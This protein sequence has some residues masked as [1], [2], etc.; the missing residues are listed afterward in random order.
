MR[1][2]MSAP[3]RLGLAITCLGHAAIFSWAASALPWRSGTTFSVSLAVLTLLHL[4]TALS[5]LLRKPNWLQWSWRALSLASAVVFVGFTW[6]LAAAALYV[7]KLYVRL[8]PPV[9]GG[10]MAAAF[11]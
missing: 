6:S 10:I 5:V 7:T 2:V 11:V 1:P 9:A 4:A 3:P 8:G